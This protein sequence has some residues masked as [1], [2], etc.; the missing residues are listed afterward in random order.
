MENLFTKRLK[1]ILRSNSFYGILFLFL[2]FFVFFCTQIVHY[3]TKF[4]ENTKCIEAKILSYS[5][6]GDKLSMVLK[7]REKFIAT[8]YISSAHEKEILESRLQVG[9]MILLNGKEREVLGQTIP[10]TFDYKK[11]LYSQRIYFAFSVETI[12]FLDKPI[13]VIYQFKAIF[14]AR[15]KK[16]GDNAYL[17]AFVLGD[18]TNLDT[19]VYDGIVN[20]GVSHLFALSGMHLSL[21]YV[22]L[23]KV[24]GKLKWK[25]I[26]IYIV[27]FGYLILTGFSVSFTRAILFFFLLDINKKFSFSLS[28]LQVLFFTA[29]F[30]LLFEPFYIYNVGFWYT[31]VVTFSLLFCHKFLQKKNKIKQTIFVSIITFLF[32]LPI[33]IFINYEVNLFSIF[34]NIIFV[35]FISSVVFPLALLTFLFPVFL[36]IFSFFTNL[37]ESINQ[38]LMSFSC[39]LIF[40]KISL[41]EVVLYY[42]FL[43]LVIQSR[44]KKFIFLFLIFL[45]FLYNKNWFDSNYYVY[46]IDVGQGDAT[47]FVAPQMKEIILVDTGGKISYEKSDYQ[48]RKREF[49]L[50]DSLISFFKS[51]RIRKIDFLLVTHGDLDHIGYASEIGKAIPFKKVMINQG[52]INLYENHLI[53][54]Y[55]QVE[56]YVS[57]YFSFF[58]FAKDVA[59][60]END[61][62]IICLFKIYDIIF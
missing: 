6:D 3:Q 55:L 14:D 41:L 23:S 9:A 39:F 52:D 10:H 56:D 46:F 13:S 15:M 36:P 62:S 37:L 5:I 49:S 31:F 43:L 7:E 30:L 12:D 11:Y 38:F 21:V 47:L 24:F 22:L 57:R 16:L 45:F 4:D 33:T 8:Y 29:F 48:V 27:L 19:N 35:P 44:K 17:N 61:N 42:V 53:S 54:N 18:K 28:N 20:N 32:S 1:I 58:T 2:S 50:S 59:K 51:L 60:N 40:G 25:K 26:C 34:N